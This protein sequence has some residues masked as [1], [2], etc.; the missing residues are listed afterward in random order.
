MKKK[1]S[2][3]FIILQCRQN[4]S[5]IFSD[6]IKYEDQGM[7]ASRFQACLCSSVFALTV[8]IAM[9][10]RDTRS[11]EDQL[12]TVFERGNT[13]TQPRNENACSGQLSAVVQM[14]EEREELS[15][16]SSWHQLSL[17]RFGDQ[18]VMQAGY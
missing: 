3:K 17:R 4:H 14:R 6:T 10:T 11:L 7:T 18:P 5:P 8:I 12:C 15:G 13:S 9:P 1:L 2:L 16:K